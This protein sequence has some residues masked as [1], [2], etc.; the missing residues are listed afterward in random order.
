[1][2][3]KEGADARVLSKEESNGNGKSGIFMIDASKGYIKDGN[4]NRLRE[5]DIHRIVDVFNSQDESD[6]KYARMVGLA[7]IERHEFNLNIPRYIDSTQPEDIQDIE[8]H[9][10]GGIP[11]RDIDA[12]SEYWSVYPNLRKS[13][14]KKADRKGYSE[15]R[16]PQ[17]EIKQTIFEHPE[18]VAYS[19]EMDDVFT[20]WKKKHR[21]KLKSIEIHTNPRDVIQPLA[22][23][24]LKTYAGRQLI[25]Q[26]DIYQHLLTYWLET[27]KDDVYMIAED[28]WQAVVTKVVRKKGDK[29]I[30]GT[31]Q[32]GKDEF[33]CDLVPK[34]LL[35]HR[36]FS[37]QWE[38]IQQLEIETESQDSKLD[39]LCE[40]HAGEEDL[41]A[42]VTS[43][44]GKVSKGNV[45]KRVKQL[46]KTNDP[47]DAEEL[48]LLEQYLD[49]AAAGSKVDKQ[50]K[51]AETK[52]EKSLL[53][54]YGELTEDD[55]K[56]L[57]VDD[58]WLATVSSKTTIE[59]DSVSHSLTSRVVELA[60]LYAIS[61]P[62]LSE[63][64][65]VLAKRV[66]THLETL[67]NA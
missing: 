46:K 23:S 31:I 44:S 45:T 53:E 67:T 21:P 40:E 60:E 38:Q 59:L 29:K 18:F 56:T 50:I 49:I 30:E 11:N 55:V 10:L 33:I 26:Y 35:I 25:D 3:D 2:L 39:E 15:L 16:V 13:L 6:P 8:A 41:L 51:A 22:E 27:M 61:L 62:S 12:L 5:Q 24:I 34:E 52:L 9:L 47:D 14:F 64:L 65:D 42:E 43:D 20:K 32:V 54:K 37:K 19:D 63:S 58:K 57:V 48:A 1:M 36:Y 28:G 66:S 17:D 7:E 4:K